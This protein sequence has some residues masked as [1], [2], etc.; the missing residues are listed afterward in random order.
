MPIPI[1]PL[2]RYSLQVTI[3]FSD[4]TNSDPIGV[5]T[6]ALSGM[7]RRANVMVLGREVADKLQLHPQII[8]GG[9]W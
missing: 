6:D 1:P 3:K 2:K 4:F 8:Q 7:L 5:I 9:L